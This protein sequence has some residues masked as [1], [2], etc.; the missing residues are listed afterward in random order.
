MDVERVKQIIIKDI[1]AHVDVAVIGLSGGADSL[2]TALLS[3]D[4][5]GKESVYTFSLPYSDTDLK[6]FNRKS[7][8]YASHIGLRHRIISVKAAADSINGAVASGLNIDSADSLSMVNSGNARAR[9]RMC[10]LYGLAHH[11]SDTLKKRARV[12]GTGNLSEDFIGYD[13]KGGDALA[14]IFPI[15]QLFKSE[16]YRLL[17]HYRD[18]GVITESMINRKPSAGLWESQTDEAEIGYSYDEMEPEIRRI[19]KDYDNVDRNTLSD[20]G[21]FVWDRHLAHKHKHEA[22]YVVQLRDASG[23]LPGESAPQKNDMVMNTME[24]P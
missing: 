7:E 10:V 23:K 20:I 21:K 6:T 9:A 8:L 16:V 22:P 4:A 12:M 19:L 13:T 15:G 1:K 11:L 24:R 5:L 17:E 2:L 18:Q 3:Q 14:D